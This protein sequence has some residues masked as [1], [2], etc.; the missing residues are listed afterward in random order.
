MSGQF[1]VHSCAHMSPVCAAVSTFQKKK[2]VQRCKLIFKK[3]FALV[4]YGQKQSTIL[5]LIYG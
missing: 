5:K 4:Y 3:E 1:H 2:E